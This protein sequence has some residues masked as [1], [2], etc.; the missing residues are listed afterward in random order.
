MLQY[1]TLRQLN[2]DHRR[3]HCATAESERL[4]RLLRETRRPARRA[5]RRQTEGPL[6][7]VLAVRPRR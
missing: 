2:E 6:H 1:D 7:L 3:T 4:A 5:E